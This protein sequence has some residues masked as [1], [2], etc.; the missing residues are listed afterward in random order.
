M[1]L[2]KIINEVLVLLD[3]EDGQEVGGNRSEQELLADGWK[4]ACEGEGE[5]EWVE[6]PACFVWV[7]TP[8]NE[9]P[10]EEQT[11]ADG[12]LSDSEALNIITGGAL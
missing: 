2:G 11:P 6:Y 12:E 5:G 9:E 8:A 7:N 4:P 1:K 3:C 10:E